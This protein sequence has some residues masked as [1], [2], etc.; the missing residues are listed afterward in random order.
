MTL[1]QFCAP[2]QLVIAGR[3]PAIQPSREIGCFYRTFLDR[4]VKPAMT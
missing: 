4:L 3:G 2:S 1:Q